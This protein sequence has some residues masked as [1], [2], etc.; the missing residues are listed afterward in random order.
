LPIAKYRRCGKPPEKIFAKSLKK[1]E[2]PL[3]FYVF[4]GL[5]FYYENGSFSLIF[6][7]AIPYYKEAIRLFHENCAF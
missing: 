2:L 6:T 4:Y 5:D 3:Y 7:I 1:K